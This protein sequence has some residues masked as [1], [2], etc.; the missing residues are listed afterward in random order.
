[1]RQRDRETEGQRD[2]KTERQ[3]DRETERHSFLQSNSSTYVNNAIITI[4][5]IPSF[6]LL[7]VKMHNFTFTAKG[8]DFVISVFL[9]VFLSICLSVFLFLSVFLCRKTF[10]NL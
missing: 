5:V 10:P 2:R 4:R 3:R 6:Y 9:S 7:P 1:M 8:S